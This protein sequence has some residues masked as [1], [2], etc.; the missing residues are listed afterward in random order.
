MNDEMDL[1]P[2]EQVAAETLLPEEGG[3]GVADGHYKGRV[4][5]EM[6]EEG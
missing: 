2:L 4:G 3:K 1:T 6:G 5:E